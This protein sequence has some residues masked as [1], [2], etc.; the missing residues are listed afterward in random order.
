MGR[1]QQGWQ[2]LAG[3]LD[4]KFDLLQSVRGRIAFVL[5]VY[6][7][8][9]RV[10]SLP[11][12]VEIFWIARASVGLSCLPVSSVAPRAAMFNAIWVRTGKSARATLIHCALHPVAAK[13]M[14]NTSANIIWV[15]DRVIDVAVEDLVIRFRFMNASPY[16]SFG[17]FELRIGMSRA[18]ARTAAP[19]CPV[20]CARLAVARKQNRH[21]QRPMAILL[22]E[23][24]EL[25]Q[26]SAGHSPV[27]QV[28]LPS[29]SRARLLK[30][31]SHQN[32][33]PE[34]AVRWA[35]CLWFHRTALKFRE[36]RRDPR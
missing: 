21:R 16:E 12:S 24:F 31:C 32:A 30:S 17:R 7:D 23:S 10:R 15:V 22:V 4:Q 2:V 14:L 33:V 27:Y 28:T 34:S 3:V 19:G 29:R 20:E 11:A 35:I 36:C 26:R 1:L 6:R 18:T 8:C 13:E 25:F 5:A 9:R